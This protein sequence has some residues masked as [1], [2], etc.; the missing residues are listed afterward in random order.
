MPTRQAPAPPAKS[1]FASSA[2][3][4]TFITGTGA[5]GIAA[6]TAYAGAVGGTISSATGGKFGNG[7]VTSSFAHLFNGETEN[8]KKLRAEKNR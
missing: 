2:T 6:R 3:V 7:A 5:G 1:T 8:L 4:P